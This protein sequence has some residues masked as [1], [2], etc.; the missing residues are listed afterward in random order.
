LRGSV[1]VATLEIASWRT[2]HKWERA[3][4]ETLARYLAP[5]WKEKKTGSG[6]KCY[7]WC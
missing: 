5:V 6:E 7:V 1:D 2:R 4:D 3:T